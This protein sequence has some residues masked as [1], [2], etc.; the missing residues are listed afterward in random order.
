MF[1]GPVRAEAI[2][3]RTMCFY[4]GEADMLLAIQLLLGLATLIAALAVVGGRRE[5]APN[6]RD[7]ERALGTPVRQLTGECGVRRRIT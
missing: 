4:R 2:H 7:A 3:V 5:S 6:A 1:Q